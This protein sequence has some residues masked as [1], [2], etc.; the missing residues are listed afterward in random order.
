MDR[1]I[2]EYHSKPSALPLILAAL[3][4]HH[5]MFR[6]VSHN[7]LLPA[8]GIEVNPEVLDTALLIAGALAARM[9]FSAESPDEVELRELTEYLYQR[10]DWCWAQDNK[11]TMRMGWKPECGFLHYGWEGYNEAMLMY[12]LAMGS[13]TDRPCAQGAG[14]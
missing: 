2:T 7:T 9:Y 13:P 12:V 1:A 10:I 5:A 14:R 6:T 4:E 3:P 8:D 11:P